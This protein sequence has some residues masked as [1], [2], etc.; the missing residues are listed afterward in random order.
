MTC[1]LPETSLGH[2]HQQTQRRIYQATLARVQKYG[3]I[4][5]K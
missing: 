4:Y 5:I 1:E 3:T 2:F